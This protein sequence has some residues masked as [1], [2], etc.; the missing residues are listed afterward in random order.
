[1]SGPPASPATSLKIDKSQ[2]RL[3][4]ERRIRDKEHLKRVAELP[5]LVCSRQPSHAHHLRFAQRRGLS[6]KVSDEYVV[7]LCA[8]HHGALHHYSSETEWWAK[9]KIDPLPVAAELWAKHR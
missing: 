2:L 3:G 1:L 9:Q 7:P 8:L 6:Q 4:V 5:C